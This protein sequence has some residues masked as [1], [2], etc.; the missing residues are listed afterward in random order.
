MIVEDIMRS[1]DTISY[2]IRNQGGADAG[3][4]VSELVVDG[5]V[6][7]SDGINPLAA[8]AWRDESFD[9][10]YACT[11]VSDSIVVRADK[12]NAVAESDEEN[13]ERSE[14][15]TCALT[16]QSPVYTL[17]LPDLVIEDVSLSGDTISYKIKNLGNAQAG[18]S[19]SALVIDG[20]V[21]SSDGVNP[22]AAGASRNESFAYSYTCT[23]VS[24]SIVV[25]ADKNNAV[26]ESNEGNNEKSES[27]G[28]TS[29]P[30][31][32]QQPVY[33]M[34]VPDL[35]VTDLWL[36]I[37]SYRYYYTVKNQGSLQASA[38][39]TTLRINDISKASDLVPPL[40]AGDSFTGMFEW[41]FS[42]TIPSQSVEVYADGQFDLTESNEQN[43]WRVEITDCD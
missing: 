19:T 14:P 3:A 13:N 34:G 36:K 10:S 42:C 41:N 40:A 23:G 11:G 31:Q 27:W 8:G 25:R 2:R 43:N 35:V 9:Y 12:D 38:T 5:V 32:P 33:T 39:V 17:S 24:D 22:L 37:P 7:S 18:A 20:V 26:A 30:Q 28:C 6:K 21:K 29:T 15:W 1:G 4:T 16:P